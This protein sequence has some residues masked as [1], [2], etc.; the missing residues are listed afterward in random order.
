MGIDSST[1]VLAKTWKWHKHPPTYRWTNKCGP[2]THGSITQP[3]KA[4]KPWHSLPRGRT[5]RTR[6]SVRD[7]DTEGHTGCESTDGKRAEQADPQTQRVGS[8]CQGLGST[9]RGV[10]ANGDRMSFGSWRM[11]WDVNTLVNFTICELYIIT[12][13]WIYIHQLYIIN[14]T[15]IAPISSGHILYLCAPYYIFVV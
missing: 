2:S 5:L 1:F 9:E 12:E 14:W 8:C 3:W 4:V 13:H 7:A 11:F 10:I 6:R 15:L